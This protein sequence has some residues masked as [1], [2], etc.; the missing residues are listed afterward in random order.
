M[1][2]SHSASPDQVIGAHQ[3]P[4]HDALLYTAHQRNRRSVGSF[5]VLSTSAAFTAVLFLQPL[6][7]THASVLTHGAR[8]YCTT[9]VKNTTAA[10]LLLLYTRYVLT[11]LL[12]TSLLESIYLTALQLAG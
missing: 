1:G 10:A 2:E 11:G 3:G 12:S 5:H 9:A 4:G 7:N 8:I 6:P